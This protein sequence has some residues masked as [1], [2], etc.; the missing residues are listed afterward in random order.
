M[1]HTS[2]PGVFTAFILVISDPTV[3]STGSPY[4]QTYGFAVL[5]CGP[6]KFHDQNELQYLGHFYNNNFESNRLLCILCQLK[7]ITEYGVYFGIMELKQ[8]NSASDRCLVRSPIS[9][10]HHDQVHKWAQFH[11]GWPGIRSSGGNNYMGQSRIGTGKDG[12]SAYLGGGCW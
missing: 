8:A 5:S 12:K 2:F 3:F 6:F 4:L 7:D 1:Y 10:P 9:V 11:N